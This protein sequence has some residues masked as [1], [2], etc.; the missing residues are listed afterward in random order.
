MFQCSVLNAYQV[1]SVLYSKLGGANILSNFLAD[2]TVHMLKRLV[3]KD[4]GFRSLLC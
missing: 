3:E 4:L 2:F 1:V